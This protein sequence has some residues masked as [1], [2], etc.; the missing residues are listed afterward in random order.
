MVDQITV[1]KADLMAV[2][3]DIE[4]PRAGERVRRLLREAEAVDSTDADSARAEGFAAGMFMAGLVAAGV[5]EGDSS[6]HVDTM[7]RGR[8]DKRF[9]ADDE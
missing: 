7:F 8:E 2:Y 3:G 1:D 9:E 4:N 6:E 5:F